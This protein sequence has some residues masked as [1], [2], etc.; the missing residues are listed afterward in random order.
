MAANDQDSIFTRDMPYRSFGQ[1]REEYDAKMNNTRADFPNELNSIPIPMRPEGGTSIQAGVGQAIDAVI[2]QN[3][4]LPPVNLSNPAYGQDQQL[5]GGPDLSNQAQQPVQNSA[6]GQIGLVSQRS[7]GG[8]GGYKIPEAVISTEKTED[9]LNQNSLVERE[10]QVKANKALA[11]ANLKTQQANEEAVASQKLYIDS[12]KQALVDQ[13]KKYDAIPKVDPRR[14]WNNA[15]NWGKATM[16]IGMLSDAAYAEVRDPSQSFTARLDKL[17]SED[18]NIQNKNIATEKEKIG[19]GYDGAIKV[20]DSQDEASKFERLA[21]LDSIGTML[22]TKLATVNPASKA[23]L[24]LAKGLAD[25]EMYK[26]KTAQEMAEQ[27]AKNL[28]NNATLGLQR[29]KNNID[30][31][32]LGLKAQAQRQAE[33]KLGSEK[34]TK[35]ALSDITQKGIKDLKN[36][37]GQLETVK[38]TPEL[39]SQTK[40]L[41]NQALTQTKASLGFM[42]SGANVAE[43]ERQS[44]VELLTP[45]LGESTDQY[46]ERVD[47]T[48]QLARAVSDVNTFGEAYAKAK[49]LRGN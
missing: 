16:L 21:K 35:V 17:I 40:S 13:Q 1:T 48:L 30:R 28:F 43:G 22:K 42:L 19:K 41:F 10:E 32:E 2:G 46:S 34:A 8:G 47:M 26:N 3:N 11:E 31:A 7:G 29:E 37:H 49:A 44:F 9:Y 23:G 4:G 45:K 12:L 18:I 25:L 33:T 27:K 39:F 24:S 38:F 20:A 6:L 14:T 36:L 15:S 5:Q